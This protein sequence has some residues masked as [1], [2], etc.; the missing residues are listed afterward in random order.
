MNE[1]KSFWI[2]NKI[3]SQKLILINLIVGLHKKWKFLRVQL[4][5]WLSAR[6]TFYRR[7]FDSSRSHPLIFWERVWLKRDSN[8]PKA[9]SNEENAD[10][11]GQ[12]VCRSRRHH[13]FSTPL[14]RG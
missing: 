10:N 11:T 1:K 8:G 13:L 6:L 5:L 9:R 3:A 2:E 7:E 12:K 14:W 4:A